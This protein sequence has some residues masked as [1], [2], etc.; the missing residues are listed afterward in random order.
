MSSTR[1]PVL[2]SR[3]ASCHS[4]STQ[5][6]VGGRLSSHLLWV[7]ILLIHLCG[8]VLVQEAPLLKNVQQTLPD[9][10]FDWAV[11]PKTLAA[12]QQQAAKTEAKVL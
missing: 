10:A 2:L 4:N 8:F 12:E 9:A 7:C 3:S 6:C 5:L 11:D 1:Q